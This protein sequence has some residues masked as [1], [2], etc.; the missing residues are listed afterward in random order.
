VAVAADLMQQLEEMK[1]ECEDLGA[2]R[3]E[4]V[5]IIITIYFQADLDHPARVRESIIGRRKG[6]L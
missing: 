6:N 2:S 3:S 5:E 4:I 1:D